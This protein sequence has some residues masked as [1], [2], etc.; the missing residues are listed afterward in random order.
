MISMI[1]KQNKRKGKAMKR[2]GVLILMTVFA[3][4]FTAGCVFA[5]TMT[6][7]AYSEYPIFGLAIGG[8]VGMALGANAL[9]DQVL[10]DIN[11]FPVYQYVHIYQGAA[12]GLTT[13]GYARGLVAGDRFVGIAIEEKNNT[14]GASA[15]LNVRVLR[16][17]VVQL[18]VGSF[19]ITDVGKVVYA[20]ADGTFTL[21]PA[22][23]WIGVALRFVASGYAEVEIDAG[24]FPSGYNNNVI[25]SGLFTT[26]GGD[27]TETITAT[28]A[29]ATDVAIV[30][31]NTKGNTP[32]TVTTAICTTSAITVTLS[33]DPSTDHVLNY[34]VIRPS[35]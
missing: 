31:V 27:A 29:V 35:A 26:L 21:T 32:R 7:P 17:G 5:S 25:A 16:K 18:P 3:F 34:V 14:A 33:G 15:A 2:F 10:G 23:S 28:G 13:G 20:T 8:L 4:V 11:E 1:K 24:W 6:M 22:S 19:A 12:V 9:R 30:T